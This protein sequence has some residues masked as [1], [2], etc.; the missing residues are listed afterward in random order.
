M[1]V[2]GQSRS[3]ASLGRV[4]GTLG[5]CCLGPGTRLPACGSARPTRPEMLGLAGV[6]AAPSLS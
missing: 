2:S 3:P 5:A 4:S 6:Q 1:R